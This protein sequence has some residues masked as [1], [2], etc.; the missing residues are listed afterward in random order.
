MYQLI[1]DSLKSTNERLWFN[2][3]LRLGKIFL[4]DKNIPELEAVLN[5]LKFTCRLPDADSNRQAADSFDKKKGQLLLEVLALEIQMCIETKE[6]RRMKDVFM[7]SNSFTSTVE[8]PRVVGIIKECG[9]KMY[10]SEK[11]WE[12]A[13]Q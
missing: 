5:E 6:S 13:R 7:L 10:M 1:L 2:T 3:S 4:D 8:D 9:G 11:R 12:L